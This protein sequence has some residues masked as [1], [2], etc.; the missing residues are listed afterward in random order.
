MRMCIISQNALKNDYAFTIKR[1]QVFRSAEIY[2]VII[3][4][5]KRKAKEKKYVRKC[6]KK[7][8]ELG[9]YRAAVSGGFAYANMLS[10]CGMTIASAES[11]VK[12][13][14]QDMAIA[15]AEA[16]SLEKE[17]LIV[18]GS[19]NDVVNAVKQ[20]LEIRRCVYL[21]CLNFEEIEMITAEDTGACVSNKIPDGAIELHMCEGTIVFDG[22]TIDIGD[23]E[24]E[25]KGIEEKMQAEVGAAVAST[26]EISGLLEKNDVKLRYLGK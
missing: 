14:L 26:L 16:L 7:L 24:M 8:I 3:N 21:N 4:T 23:Y 1:A 17:F 25:I 11:F 6:A 20:L 18:G 19:C 10:D 9:I 22:R 13:H 2:E 12:R 5:A 15:F